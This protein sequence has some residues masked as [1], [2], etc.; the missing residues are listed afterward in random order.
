VYVQQEEG[1][2]KC[3]RITGGSINPV[4]VSESRE[5]SHSAFTGLAISANGGQDR[6]GILWITTGYQLD[7]A[8][9]GI[10]RAFDASDLSHELWNS[11]LS[12]GPD[13]PGAFAKF[14]IPTV[15]DGKVYV[16][17]FSNVIAVYG[18][19]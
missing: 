2:L 8:I 11:D 12:G 7:P 18:L 1:F 6:S 10:L 5:W 14:A 4:P 16:P 19:L 17:T 15:A 13:R 9:T 3:Y